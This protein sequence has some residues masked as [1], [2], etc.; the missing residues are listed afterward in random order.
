MSTK[1]LLVMI[2][3]NENSICRTNNNSYGD[4]LF[5][6]IGRNWN[7]RKRDKISWKGRKTFLFLDKKNTS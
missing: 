4:S 1:L 2:D 6:Q 5:L 7:G 3:D